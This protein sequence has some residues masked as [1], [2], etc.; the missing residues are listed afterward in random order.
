[1]NH[2]NGIKKQ[3]RILIHLNL[4]H[5]E[6][7]IKILEHCNGNE[8]YKY[9]SKILILRIKNALTKFKD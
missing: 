5:A 8:Y 4:K 6:D 2:K 1:M 7:I 9:I 3:K